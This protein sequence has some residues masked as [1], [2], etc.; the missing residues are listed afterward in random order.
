MMRPE[1][2]IFHVTAGDI[3]QRQPEH[4]QCHDPARTH[5][6]EEEICWGCEWSGSLGKAKIP[7]GPVRMQR[8]ANGLPANKGKQKAMKI[9]PFQN[10]QCPAL[11]LGDDARVWYQGSDTARAD[12]ELSGEV[13]STC[14]QGGLHSFVPR[15]PVTKM[16]IDTLMK[17]VSMER[18]RVRT[19]AGMYEMFESDNMETK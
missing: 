18:Q 12:I 4:H 5:W 1:K 14:V 8:A 7:S 3:Q 13:P 6:Q 9:F 19:I 16:N 11:L 10:I 15:L 17:E 2:H